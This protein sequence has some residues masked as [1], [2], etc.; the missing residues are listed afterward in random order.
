MELKKQLKE[1]FGPSWKGAILKIIGGGALFFLVI[2]VQVAQPAIDYWPTGFPFVFYWSGGPCLQGMVCSG[3]NIWA[4][5][6]DIAFWYL[7]FCLIIYA[8]KKR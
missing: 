6:F 5:I 3:S 8:W 2:F 4:L 7:A 1:F